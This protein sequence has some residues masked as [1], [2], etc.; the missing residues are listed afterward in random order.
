M[1]AVSSPH[2]FCGSCAQNRT[3]IKVTNHNLKQKNFDHVS[4]LCTKKFH[5]HIV[6]CLIKWTPNKMA[7]NILLQEV[8]SVE[9]TTIHYFLLQVQLNSRARYKNSCNM[10]CI[11]TPFITFQV[12]FIRKKLDFLHKEYITKHTFPICVSFDCKTGF[13]IQQNF[14][15][16]SFFRI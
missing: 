16:N 1:Y 7:C 4:V 10:C 12:R 11:F 8:I 3:V 13:S 6:S 15:S 14:Y 9:A 2:C 5:K